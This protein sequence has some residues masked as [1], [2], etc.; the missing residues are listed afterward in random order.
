[1]RH[2]RE[3]NGFIP[4]VFCT[5]WTL[6]P[7]KVL[8]NALIP[9]VASLQIKL[10]SSSSASEYP[11]RMTETWEV[12]RDVETAYRVHHWHRTSSVDR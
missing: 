3:D 10:S 9:L 6:Y 11:G 8:C 5:R 2:I 12:K 7:I 4:K 1:M